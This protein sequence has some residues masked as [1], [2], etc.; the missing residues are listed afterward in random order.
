MLKTHLKTPA[1]SFVNAAEYVS[2]LQRIA[3]L[4]VEYQRNE[5]VRVGASANINTK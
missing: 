2:Y 1:S 4:Q 5:L 3:K